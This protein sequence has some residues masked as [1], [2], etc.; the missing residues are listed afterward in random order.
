MGS[1]FVWRWNPKNKLL[2]LAISENAIKSDDAPKISV[3]HY[4]PVK[5]LLALIKHKFPIFRHISKAIKKASL[6]LFNW[7]PT[8]KSTITHTK[9]ET[10]N[11]K[12]FATLRRFI[13]PLR[14]EL[15]AVLGIHATVMNNFPSKLFANPSLV[16]V[17]MCLLATLQGCR[18][19]TIRIFRYFAWL[20]ISKVQILA[21]RSEERERIQKLLELLIL[22]T[23]FYSLSLPLL[24]G[25]IE[26]CDCELQLNVVAYQTHILFGTHI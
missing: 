17:C 3:E 15:V 11:K 13:E 8:A 6:V 22:E 10:G 2:T 1:V 21:K 5:S 25:R 19:F 18:F 9:K 14:I 20:W 16:L 23:I 7:N 24:I 26:N 12:Q 4:P